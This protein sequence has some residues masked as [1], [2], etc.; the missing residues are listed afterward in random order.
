MATLGFRVPTQQAQAL[1]ES[2]EQMGITQSQ[3]LRDA[4]RRYLI[5]LRAE[6]DIAAWNAK[7]LTEEE[8]IFAEIADWGPEEDWSDSADAKAGRVLSDAVGC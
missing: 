1:R 8:K 6:H 3:L 2:A 7:P 4:L 5:R